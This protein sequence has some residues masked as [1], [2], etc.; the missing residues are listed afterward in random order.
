MRPP[1]FNRRGQVFLHFGTFLA[2]ARPL[3]PLVERLL[4]TGE[5]ALVWRHGALNVGMRGLAR[6]AHSGGSQSL[7]IS[8]SS[9]RKVVRENVKPLDREIE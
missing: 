7:R 1:G 5:K 3:S 6:G 4:E 2:F 8:D 9:Q